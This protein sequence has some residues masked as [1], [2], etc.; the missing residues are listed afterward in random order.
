MSRYGS[1]LENH[2]Q[3]IA[4]ELKALHPKLPVGATWNAAN[5]K[6]T[7]TIK[8][9]T[10]ELDFERGDPITEA[11]LLFLNHNHYLLTVLERR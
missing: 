2:V 7:A 1:I 6:L 3:G 8:G 10:F 4:Q 9:E 5:G 11:L